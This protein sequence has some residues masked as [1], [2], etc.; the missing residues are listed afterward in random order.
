MNKDR[1]FQRRAVRA[2]FATRALTV[3]S[4]GI[5]GVVLWV[6]VS[7][8]ADTNEIVNSTS[9]QLHSSQETLERVVDCTEP[10]GKCF[11]RNTERTTEAV[12]SIGRLSVYASACAADPHLPGKPLAKRVHEIKRCVTRLVENERR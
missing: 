8:S 3:L 12:D 4:V 7:V 9:E 11:Q 1:E 5:L 10:G 6:L 2:E